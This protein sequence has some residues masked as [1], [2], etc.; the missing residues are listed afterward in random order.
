MFQFSVYSGFAFANSLA[1]RN[2]NLVLIDLPDE[3]LQKAK[4]NIEERYKVKVKQIGLD[5]TGD[6]SIY[7]SIASE[8]SGLD[9]GVLINNVGICQGGVPAHQMDNT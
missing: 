3:R 4:S 5:F 2:L 6:S 7:D 9:I 1:G 8:I